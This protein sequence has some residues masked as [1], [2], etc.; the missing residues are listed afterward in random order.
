M[1]TT[2]FGVIV[3][4]AIPGAMLSCQVNNFY[5][6]TEHV[7]QIE[8]TYNCMQTPQNPVT[9]HMSTVPCIGNCDLKPNQMG[10]YTNGP[11]T[12]GCQLISYS[13]TAYTTP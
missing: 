3:G 12:F 6:T 13:C 9:F 2:L 10:F 11:M 7:S 5:Q 4:Q 1:I 8:Y